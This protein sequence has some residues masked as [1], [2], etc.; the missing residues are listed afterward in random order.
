MPKWVVVVI[1]L[2]AL[3]AALWLGMKLGAQQAADSARVPPTDATVPDVSEASASD[4]PAPDLVSRAASAAPL[5][6]V[7]TP[8]AEVFDDLVARA[9][10]GDHRAA[11]RLALELQTCGHDLGL[12]RLLAEGAARN[13]SVDLSSLDNETLARMEAIVA[14]GERTFDHF[15]TLVAHCR[16][17][18]EVS[19]G[20]RLGWWRQAAFAGHPAAVHEYVGGEAFPAHLWIRESA[21]LQAYQ[22]DLEGLAWRTMQSGDLEMAWRL[23]NAHTPNPPMMR[24]DPLAQVLEE[25]AEVALA[26]ALYLRDAAEGASGIESTLNGFRQLAD[27]LVQHLSPGLDA[28]GVERAAARSRDWLQEIP[29]RP[30]DSSPFH[31]YRFG[32]EEGLRY[33]EERMRSCAATDLDRVGAA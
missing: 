14:H 20:R 4:P 7:D 3:G 26:L 29:P 2:G 17:V 18:P 12:A 19:F 31:R 11:C 23:M 13:D 22:R 6:P 30:V 24:V 15:E 5:P 25:D 16:G 1:A 33:R 8:L 28:D 9:D 32:E 10:R 21:H 27:T